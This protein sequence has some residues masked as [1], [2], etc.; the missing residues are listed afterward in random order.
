M[1]KQELEE[2]VSELENDVDYWQHECHELEETI[3][4]LEEQINDLELTDG[5]KDVNNFI[6]ALE[7]KGLYNAELEEFIENYLRFCNG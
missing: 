3:D 5:I 7:I 6:R 2:K 1:T 4:K